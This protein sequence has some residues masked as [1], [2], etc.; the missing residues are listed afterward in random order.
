M[1]VPGVTAAY[2]YPLRR[3]LG[4][5]DVVITSGNDLPSP[6]VIA[7]AQAHIDD[8]RPV[9][10]KNSLVLAPTPRNADFIIQVAL[11]GITLADA[12]VQINNAL[13]S[14]F[15]Q[16]PPGAPA[17]LS[18]I[19]PLIM[20]IPGIIDMDFVHPTKNIIPRVD[21]EVVEWVRMGT[22]DV[23]DMPPDGVILSHPQRGRV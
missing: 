10:A 13:V 15:S 14:Y 1:E 9:T 18:N 8:V 5:V 17:R 11:S 23:Q 20:S 4:T 2:V 7:A 19:Y 16:L 22:L 6:Q 12:K 21:E 3:G